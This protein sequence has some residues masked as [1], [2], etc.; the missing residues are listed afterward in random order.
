MKPQMLTTESGPL[1]S[2]K[3]VFGKGVSVLDRNVFQRKKLSIG[4]EAETSNFGKTIPTEDYFSLNPCIYWQS[5]FPT[6]SQR[7]QLWSELG[8]TGPV[9]KWVPPWI[10]LHKEYS[11]LCFV[12]CRRIFFPF[13]VADVVP[14]NLL[15]Q[16]S[17]CFD[18][19]VNQANPFDVNVHVMWIIFEE[20]ERTFIGSMHL[21][22]LFTLGCFLQSV[23]QIE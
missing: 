20:I 9:Y 5:F 3:L 16:K 6:F 15:L 21:A 4:H 18:L 14:C 11:L 7:N 10:Y 17:Y 13:D 23:F 12:R 8:G 1:F 22:D 2:V 19:P